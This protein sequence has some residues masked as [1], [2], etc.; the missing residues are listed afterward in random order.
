GDD[1]LPEKYTP[2]EPEPLPTVAGKPGAAPA[3]PAAPKRTDGVKFDRAAGWLAFAAKHPSAFTRR[4]R[5]AVREQHRRMD[6]SDAK[7]LQEAVQ[8]RLRALQALQMIREAMCY[9][10]AYGG[11]ALLLGANDF[12]T[13][14]RQPLDLKRVRSLDYLTPLEARELIPLY[15]YNDPRAPKFGQ[16]AI[17]QLV[18]FVIGAAVDPANQP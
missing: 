1:E 9:E 8:K 18:P 15:Y 10:R 3:K 11:G 2:P 13:D 16:V 6:A 4:I 5:V 12:A 14:L 7:P 17:Y